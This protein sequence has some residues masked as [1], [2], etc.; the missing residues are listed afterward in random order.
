MDTVNPLGEI[1]FTKYIEKF[2]QE[3]P[4]YSSKTIG[5]TQLHELSR[6]NELPDEMPTKEVE[7]YSITEIKK[8]EV[9]GKDLLATICKKIDCVKGDFRQNEI[10]RQWTTILANKNI[11]FKV[12]KIRVFCSSGTYMRSLASRLGKNAGTG[13]FAL[14]IHRTK[15]GQF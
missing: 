8:S 10:K 5:G 13:A 2:S 9:Q 3:Y 15:V 1:D 6:K 7:I 14:S 4:A 12:L 11:W